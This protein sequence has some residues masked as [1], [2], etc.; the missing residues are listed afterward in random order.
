MQ[1]WNLEES[2]FPTD[3]GGSKIIA[4]T[5]EVANKIT[6]VAGREIITVLTACNAS[7]KAIE[8]LVIFTG[9]NFQ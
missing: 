6:S 4:P 3:A 2:G 7:G 9:K 8:R 5:G 1:I